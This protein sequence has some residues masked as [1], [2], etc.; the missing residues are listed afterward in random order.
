MNVRSVNNHFDEL[1]I[2]VSSFKVLPVAICLTETWGQQC[3]VD[4]LLINSY[5][6]PI[7]I[8]RVNQ[9]SGVILYV[10][11]E[12]IPKQISIDTQAENLTYEL[13]SESNKFIV[14]CIYNAPGLGTKKF[15]DD[16]EMLLNSLNQYSVLSCVVGDMNIDTLKD[17]TERKQYMSILNSNGFLQ[18]I[19]EPTRITDK[20]KTSID[21]VLVSKCDE[22]MVSCG[23]INSAITDHCSTYVELPAVSNDRTSPSKGRN[24][25]FLLS[26]RK[27][28]AF[29]EDIEKVFNCNWGSDVEDISN[30][31]SLLLSDINMVIDEYAT[32]DKPTGKR[33]SPP[34][35]N[36]R[37]R[38]MIT[39][40]KKLYLQYTTD[41]CTTSYNRFRLYRTKVS[42]AIR[43]DKNMYYNKLFES[44]IYDKHAFF[45]HLNYVTGRT[46]RYTVK[47]VVVDDNEYTKPEDIAEKFN[48]HFSTIGQTINER[49]APCSK[50]YAE[51]ETEFSMFL[52]PTTPTEIIRII[53]NLK[54]HKAFGPDGIPAE[55][56]KHCASEL[57]PILSD[58]INLSF[59]Q[60]CFPNCLGA[61]KVIPLYKSGDKTNVTSYRPISLLSVISK[62]F[63]SVMYT[64]ISEFLEK[65]QLLT[66]M[67]PRHDSS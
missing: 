20:T 17:S 42:R 32:L 47:K 38:N 33:S 56:I 12:Y 3:D 59:S 60:G 63:E 36:N 8:A 5:Q 61:A 67:P 22:N 52:R 41:G 19:N 21:H 14:S 23:V 10:H 58:L 16:I 45:R 28:R 13:S 26:Q 65:Y 39:K 40:R 51:K 9:N 34:W 35:Y 54:S 44:C 50:T 46:Y 64:R 24:L 49:I 1:Q 18:M 29:C 30:K 53:K 57:A 15:L 62:I 11:D 66:V 31:C 6:K 55:I 25:R 37:L 43:E 48:E 2:L 7:H 27:L 4:T